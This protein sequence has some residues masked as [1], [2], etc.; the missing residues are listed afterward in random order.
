MI[1]KF[2]KKKKHTIRK[3]YTTLCNKKQLLLCPALLIILSCWFRSKTNES[4]VLD[5]HVSAGGKAINLKIKIFKVF[6]SG[7]HFLG[8]N[9]RCELF[10]GVLVTISQNLDEREVNEGMF[11]LYWR[12]STVLGYCAKIRCVDFF[13]VGHLY[14]NRLRVDKNRV[15]KYWACLL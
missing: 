4:L 13:R 7:R 15:R 11:L 12:D 9:K 3:L 2:R 6:F 1:Y 10:L 14:R 8:I 5:L